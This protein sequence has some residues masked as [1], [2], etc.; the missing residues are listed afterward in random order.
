MLEKLQRSEQ[1]TNNLV[2]QIEEYRDC[3]RRIH[4]LGVEIDCLRVENRAFDEDIKKMRL[5]YS[6][7][8]SLE[9]KKLVMLQNFLMAAEIESLRRRVDEREI[10]VEEL[11]KSILEPVRRI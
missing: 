5:K 4:I 1:E 7:S 8:I 2:R 6:D 11:R 10:S 9:K 3:A